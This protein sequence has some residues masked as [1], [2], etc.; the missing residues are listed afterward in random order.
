MSTPQVYYGAPPYPPFDQHG[1]TGPWGY[2]HYPPAPSPGPFLHPGDP[3]PT[4]NIP[5][6]VSEMQVHTDMG[7]MQVCTDVGLTQVHADM[8]QSQANNQPALTKL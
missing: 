3:Q 7:P 5:V 4:S 6:Q 8:G 1:N 2:G